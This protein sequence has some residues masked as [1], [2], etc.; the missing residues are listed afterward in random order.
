MGLILTQILALYLIFVQLGA[1]AYALYI[2]RTKGQQELKR[3]QQSKW[4]RNVGLV[5]AF[6]AFAICL[7]ILLG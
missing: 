6:V 2:G 5:N 4:Y 3:V 7:L 1:L